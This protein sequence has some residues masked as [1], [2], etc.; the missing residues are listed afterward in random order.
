M[1]KHSEAVEERIEFLRSPGAKETEESN[2]GLVAPLI[3][4][5]MASGRTHADVLLFVSILLKPSGLLL[6]RSNQGIGTACE[7]GD[8]VCWFRVQLIDSEMSSLC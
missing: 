2:P 3:S 6:G 1:G 5:V 7:P 4:G 8:I